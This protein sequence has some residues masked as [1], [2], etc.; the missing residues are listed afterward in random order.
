MRPQTK[1]K[2]TGETLAGGKSLLGREGI[3]THISPENIRV[4]F[5]NGQVK[6]IGYFPPRGSLRSVRRR[7]Q[8]TLE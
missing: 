5:H 7:R 1:V 8:G 6:D 2:V 3:I 4:V